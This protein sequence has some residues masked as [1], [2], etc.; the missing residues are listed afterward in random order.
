[1]PEQDDL[2]SLIDANPT[3]DIVER[4]TFPDAQPPEKARPSN[5][6]GDVVP[7][8]VDFL[9][10][11][12]FED[13]FGQP[14]GLLSLY[15]PK[16]PDRQLF[17]TIETE[18]IALTSPPIL[19][20]KLDHLHNNIDS[21]YGEATRRDGYCAP[22]TIYGNYEDSTMEQELTQWGLQELEELE[23]FF[24]YNHLFNTIGDKIQIGDV[25]ETYDGKLYEV[26]S[27]LLLDESLW[28][29]QHNKVVAKKLTTEGI[30][31][32]G[33]GDITRSPNAGEQV[34]EIAD[35]PEDC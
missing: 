14:N 18:L 10:Q 5:P 21:L 35:Q 6:E 25:V 32:P 28:R 3:D 26:M 17:D 24:N 30:F 2:Y 7:E 27:S 15:D 11:H 8:T 22:I 33:K 31:L 34:I 29:A 1:M 20:Y 9:Q 16:N 12:P 19:Y 4:N 23:I 13:Q